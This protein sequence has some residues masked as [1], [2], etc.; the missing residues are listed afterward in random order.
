MQFNGLGRQLISFKH[1][2][3]LDDEYLKRIFSFHFPRILTRLAYVLFWFYLI[4]ATDLLANRHFPTFLLLFLFFSF[5]F[6]L[7]S[8]D[9][10]E[11]QFR[12]M[13][14]RGRYLSVCG[15]YGI[16]RKRLP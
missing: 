14:F 6:T 7:I 9:G 3:Q 8:S 4:L 5:Q 2:T 10:F 12:L 15:G 13:V 1:S 11:S 16:W